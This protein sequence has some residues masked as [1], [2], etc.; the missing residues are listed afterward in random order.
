MDGVKAGNYG[1]ERVAFV[2][3]CVTSSESAAL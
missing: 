3:S 2:Y 1:N